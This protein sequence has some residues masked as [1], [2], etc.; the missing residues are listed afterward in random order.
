MG[1]TER[2]AATATPFE[3]TGGDR[4]FAPNAAAHVLACQAM[5]VHLLLGMDQQV[6]AGVDRAVPRTRAPQPQAP[7]QQYRRTSALGMAV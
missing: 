6:S 3:M 2:L 1:G 4:E 5:V 7:A